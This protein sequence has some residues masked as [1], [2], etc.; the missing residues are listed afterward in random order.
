M[1]EK[2]KKTFFKFPLQIFFFKYLLFCFLE[3]SYLNFKA[4]SIENTFS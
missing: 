1:K 3:L 2:S 4:I